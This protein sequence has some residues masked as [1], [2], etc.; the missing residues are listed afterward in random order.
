MT[1]SRL[2][3]WA[4][5]P[6]VSSLSTAQAVT[7]TQNGKDQAA[8]I[9]S[10]NASTTE[11]FAAEELQK[12]IQRI[13]G[14]KLKIQ[15][16][17]A[18]GA[19]ITIAVQPQGV[20]P[21]DADP[22]ALLVRSKG[23]SLLLAGNSPRATLYASY[24]LLER[25]GV[26]YF[27][28]DFE[29]Y[30]GNSE[31]Y[32]SQKS[33]D[34]ADFEL[35]ESPSFR[36]RRKYIEEG[37]SHTPKT[38]P[39]LVDWLAKKRLNVLVYPYNYQNA[40]H[41]RWDAFRKQLL[42]EIEKRGLWLE[43][44]GHGYQ[45]FLP[46][47]KYKQQNPDWFIEGYN[48]FNVAN[49]AA[50]DT[51][52]SNVIAYLKERPEIRIFD[53]WPPDGAKWAPQLIEKYGSIPNAAAH[54][55]N[56]LSKRLQAELP[57]VSVEVISYVPNVEPPDADKMLDEKTFVNFT[58]Y[59]RSY[60]DLIFEGEYKFNVTFNGIIE[61]WRNNGFKGN[62]GI[63]EYYRKYAW[64]SLP[65]SLPHLIGAEVPHY[66][67]QGANGLGIYSEPADWIT[68]EV[69]HAI[70]ADLS[71]NTNQKSSQWL[72]SYL[73]DRF[74]PAAPALARYYDQ[75]ERGSRA[76][77]HKQASGD[78]NNAQSV[79]KSRNA[80]LAAQKALA[81][82]K[83]LAPAKSPAAFLVE[84]LNWNLEYALA[85]LDIASAT[86]EKDET[87][88]AEAKK[89][90]QELL[91]AHRFDGILLQNTYSVRRYATSNTPADREQQRKTYYP[92][93]HNQWK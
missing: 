21:A 49:D 89:R 69:N 47:S 87:K 36:Y 92:L 39:K 63:Y 60:N 23:N 81:D 93:Y 43:V 54:V 68:Y 34:L 75:V 29:F 3:L 53:A 41:T 25:L 40:G 31:Y 77:L 8:I 80:Y 73:T 26:R 62:A 70:V 5:V 57:N 76:L 19:N 71:W 1:Y 27:A 42:P 79:R 78:F 18:K 50:V 88:A 84:R 72:V 56:R 38:L 32:P 66:L 9:V 24:A 13:S 20:F 12:G 33:V 17:Q 91:E 67:K 35:R 14:A 74:G 46:P 64:H 44:G 82:A 85:D 90:F 52:I 58:T 22:D 48:V 15:Q 61:K 55:T 6:L 16:K 59:G 7:L 65:V 45:S 4:L 83:Q 51:Y 28:P 86:L 2:K 37:W 11:K 10:P 30:Q